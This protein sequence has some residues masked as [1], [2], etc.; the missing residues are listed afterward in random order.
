MKVITREFIQIKG[1]MN[2]GCDIL[3]LEFKMQIC[4]EGTTLNDF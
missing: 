4:Q 2:E 1:L 3:W